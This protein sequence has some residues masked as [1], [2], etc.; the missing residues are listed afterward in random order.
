MAADRGTLLW[1]YEHTGRLPGMFHE[2]EELAGHRTDIVRDEDAIFASRRCQNVGV[3]RTVR[4][5]F[6]CTLKIDGWFAT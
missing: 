4:D 1:K 6:L 3:G 2:L 5:A